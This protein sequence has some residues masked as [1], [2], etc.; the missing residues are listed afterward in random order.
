MLCQEMFLIGV[1]TSNFNR[2]HNNATVTG[3]NKTHIYGVAI[4][5]SLQ[6]NAPY[7][8]TIGQ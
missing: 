2:L 5:T 4:A 6:Y 1:S 7:N 3:R 8:G